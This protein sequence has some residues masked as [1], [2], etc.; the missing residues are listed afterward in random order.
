MHRRTRPHNRRYGFRPQVS[1]PTQSPSYL[2][3]NPLISLESPCLDHITSADPEVSNGHALMVSATILHHNHSP[4]SDGHHHHTH[5][6][7][8]MPA[9]GIE[10]LLK[11]AESMPKKDHE[12]TPVQ[13]WDLLRKHPEF[14]M[15]EVERLGVL[16]STL[17][18]GI[19]C[20]GYVAIFLIWRFV[21][22]VIWC[23]RLTWI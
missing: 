17:V 10:R 6:H 23:E 21:Y 7:W 3:L 13:A 15:L 1:L 4:I 20:Y 19:K 9:S 2:F 14:G 8:Q 5:N 18:Q 12:L 11:L 22:S 16:K